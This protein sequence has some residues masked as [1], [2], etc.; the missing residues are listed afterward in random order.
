[1]LLPGYPRIPARSPYL[2]LAFCLTYSQCIHRINLW[3][4]LIFLSVRPGLPGLDARK[5][6]GLVCLD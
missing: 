2:F 4:K 6:E 1:M 5:K 3:E